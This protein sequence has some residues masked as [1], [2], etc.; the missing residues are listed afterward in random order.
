MEECAYKYASINERINVSINKCSN[1]F[2]Y[3]LTI[4]TSWTL[5]CV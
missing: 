2:V 3:K 4:K 5:K 1:V